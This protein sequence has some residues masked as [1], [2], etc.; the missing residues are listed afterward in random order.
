MA[1]GKGCGGRTHQSVLKITTQSVRMSPLY[2]QHLSWCSHSY[3]M[4]VMER[5]HKY[6]NNRM[7]RGGFP[8]VN[9]YLD[10]NQE[11][12]IDD[13]YWYRDYRDGVGKT[14]RWI[15]TSQDGRSLSVLFIDKKKIGQLNTTGPVLQGICD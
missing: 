1:L 3:T 13:V 15:W 4:Y 9:E 6:Y 12:E 11:S 8:V 2:S 5:Y 14:Y 7:K 10:Y